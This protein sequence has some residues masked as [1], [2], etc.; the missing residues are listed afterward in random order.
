MLF[1]MKCSS[2]P[3]GLFTTHSTPTY[4]TALQV[5]SFQFFLPQL[6]FNHIYILF[7]SDGNTCS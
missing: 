7:I 1:E 5:K 3:D 6:N 4:P 2:T